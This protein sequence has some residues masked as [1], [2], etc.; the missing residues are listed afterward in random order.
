MKIRSRTKDKTKKR[1]RRI[2]RT[3][4]KIF[5]TASRPRLCVF[6][7][8]NH[9]YAQVIDDEGRKTLVSASDMD[10]KNKKAKKAILAREVGKILG[11]RML[12]KKIKEII[13]DKRGYK[14]HGRIKELAEGAR[15]SGLKF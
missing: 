4:A 11:E 14:Y 5:G 10:L 8:L 6:R 3:R 15:E 7:S 12:E 1:A 9:I 13:F 2:N